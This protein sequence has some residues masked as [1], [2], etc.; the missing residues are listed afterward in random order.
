MEL[1][2]AAPPGCGEIHSG[3]RDGS[4]SPFRPESRERNQIRWRT[5]LRYV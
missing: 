5:V 2:S 4:W 1:R 3:E